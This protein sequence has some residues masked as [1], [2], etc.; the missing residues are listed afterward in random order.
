MYLSVFKQFYY[1]KYLLVGE[2]F[3]FVGMSYFYFV[4][5]LQVF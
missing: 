4:F 2:V 1:L 3:I 5:F